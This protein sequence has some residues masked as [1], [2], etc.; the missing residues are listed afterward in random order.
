MRLKTNQT[1]NL[2]V[3]NVTPSGRY[4]PVLGR[5]ARKNTS[6]FTLVEVVVC[7]A[8]VALIFGGI[9]TSYIQSGKRL[10][11]TGYSLAAQQM[12]NSVL[13]QARSGVWDPT[14]PKNDMTNLNLQSVTYTASN[15]SYTYTGYTTGILDVP[16]A[17][18]NY[19]LATSYVTDQ[20]VNVST[21]V[22]VQFL[23]VDTVWPFGQW[24]S[25][26]FYTNTVVTMIAPDN[27]STTSF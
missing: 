11:W 27:R 7:T 24:R 13:E 16:Y 17:S 15:N 8:I 25:M 1:E 18:T 2:P 22:Q 9:I 23:R 10:Q 5:R 6:G 4:A 12:A 14:I 21:N 3:N 20:L 19:V 26:K